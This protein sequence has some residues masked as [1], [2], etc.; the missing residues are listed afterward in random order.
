M[1]THKEIKN[2]VNTRIARER[3]REREK[4]NKLSKVKE[5]RIHTVSPVT[6]N[7]HDMMKEDTV[8][9]QITK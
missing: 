1:K 7:M 2:T 4:L 8:I 5:D 9:T 3:E 6:S